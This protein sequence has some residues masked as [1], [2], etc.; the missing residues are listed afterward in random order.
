[1]NDIDY[2]VKELRK[3]ICFVSFRSLILKMYNK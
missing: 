1:M 3:K 2:V